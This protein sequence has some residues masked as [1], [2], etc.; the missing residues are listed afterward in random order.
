MVQNSNYYGDFKPNYIAGNNSNKNFDD[1]NIIGTAHRGAMTCQY[2]FDFQL[3][4]IETY[5][6]SLKRIF[7][8]F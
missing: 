6:S 3:I 2:G 1:C 5:K 8:E 7:K 4:R